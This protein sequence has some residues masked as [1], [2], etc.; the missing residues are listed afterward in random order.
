[1]EERR[2]DHVQ[3][4]DSF[5]ESSNPLTNAQLEL[6]SSEAS[7]IPDTFSTRLKFNAKLTR[8][9]YIVW[10]WRSPMFVI[11]VLFGSSMITCIFVIYLLFR[12]WSEY[13][14]GL[15]DRKEAYDAIDSDDMEDERSEDA[16]DIRDDQ[17]LSEFEEGEQ[18]VPLL[19]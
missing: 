10:A 2:I 5:T 4:L 12:Q 18:L 16:D 14:K 7:D 19:D 11:F 9:Q 13:A 3:L 1:M 15:S 8:L 6:S 17:S